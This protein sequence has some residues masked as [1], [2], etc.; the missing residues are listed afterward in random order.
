MNCL[1]DRNDTKFKKLFFKD[2]KLA[3]AILIN[4]IAMAGKLKKKMGEDY[5]HLLNED[6]STKEKL[7]KI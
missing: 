5:S 6:L 4:D 2:G 7:G 3:G 1:R